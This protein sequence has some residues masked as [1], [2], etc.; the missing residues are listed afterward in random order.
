MNIGGEFTT[1]STV[2]ALRDLA[3]RIDRLSTVPALTEVGPGA[4]GSVDAVFSPATSFGRFPIA[5]RITP[6]ATDAT[7]ARLTVHGWRGPHVFD[8]RLALSYAEAAL[9]THVTWQA[10]V[11]VRGP[12]ASVAQRVACDVARRAIGDVL[13][14]AADCAEKH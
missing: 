3:S 13:S 4:D 8:V 9:G 10:E 7:G 14:S 12:A 5:V 11:D 1:A 2:D 6:Q